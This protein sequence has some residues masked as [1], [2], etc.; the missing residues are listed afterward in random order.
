LFRARLEAGDRS[1]KPG[2]V[3]VS[4]GAYNTRDEVDVLADALWNIARGKQ[5]GRYAL[6]R[7]SGEFAPIGW[8]PDPGDH[9]SIGRAALAR[10]D[11]LSGVPL[12]SK[13]REPNMPLYRGMP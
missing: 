1:A 9:F 12:T 11:A 4:F 3:R 7:S 13:K 10:I 6:E 8:A 2:M 5:K